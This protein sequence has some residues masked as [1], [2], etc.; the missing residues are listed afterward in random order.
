MG[1]HNVKAKIAAKAYPESNISD[2]AD[3]AALTHTV[4]TGADGTTPSGAENDK[5]R[6]DLTA[7]RVAVVANNAAIESIIDALEAWG[8]TADS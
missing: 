8:I 3:C 1:A 2:P 4:G 7:L 5:S 6:A